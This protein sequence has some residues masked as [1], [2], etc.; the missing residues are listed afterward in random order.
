MAPSNRSS[1]AEKLAAVTSATCSATAKRRRYRKATLFT[2]VDSLLDVGVDAA[3]PESAYRARL[4]GERRG[5]NRPQLFA[6]EIDLVLG[7]DTGERQGKRRVSERLGDGKIAATVAE[8]F[9]V[10]RLQV[11]RREVRPRRN[12]A[13]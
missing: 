6:D 10:K 8:S 13:F 4:T 12:P 7:H 11:D 2:A 5:E 3:G 1:S 9:G